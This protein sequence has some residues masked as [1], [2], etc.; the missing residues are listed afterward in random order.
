MNLK[1]T[2]PAAAGTTRRSF[3][4]GVA[5]AGAGT[6]AAAGVL[7]AAGVTDLLAEAGAVAGERTEF[8]RF[9]AIAASSAD[10]VEV[11]DGCRADVLISWGDEFGRPDGTTFTYGFNNDFLAF[12]PLRGRPDEG[13]LFVN[14]EYPSPFFLHGQE[15]A[16]AKSPDQLAI[17]RYAVGNS[18]LHV[19]RSREGGWDVIASPYNRRITGDAPEI[20]V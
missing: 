19:R 4:R 13:L 5:R 3:I 18:V 14:H 17:E 1:D 8:S 7:E 15:D 16:A 6:F 10:A 11:P 9:R 12:L 2:T 20:A